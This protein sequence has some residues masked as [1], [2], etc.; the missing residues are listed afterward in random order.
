[1]HE[2][3]GW[4]IVYNVYEEDFLLQDLGA[5][6]DHRNDDW[7]IML[8]LRLSTYLRWLDLG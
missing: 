7:E 1:M 2:L 5:R 6:V 8:E 4:D 3:L